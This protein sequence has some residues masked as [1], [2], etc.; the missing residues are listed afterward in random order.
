M[1]QEP[2]GV[3]ALDQRIPFL[4]SQLGAYVA[5]AFKA[6]LEP[7]GLH[8]RATAVLLA[9][10]GTDGQSQRELCERLGLHRNVMVALIDALEAEGLVERRPHPADR[11]AFAVS[12]TERARHLV[13]DLDAA[14]RVLEDE[15]TASLT[16]EERD[17]LRNMLRRLSAAAGL[18]P[19]VHPGLA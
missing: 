3:S 4:L 12:L 18:I 19:G 14:G 5:E 9:L 7:L 1:A 11:R 8:P 2:T 6:R 15:V 13:P 16:D 10:A 17:L